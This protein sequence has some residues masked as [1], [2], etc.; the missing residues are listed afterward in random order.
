MNWYYQW[1][2]NR[3]V[4]IKKV[5]ITKRSKEKKERMS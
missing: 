4:T 3:K 2:T 5:K 1:K